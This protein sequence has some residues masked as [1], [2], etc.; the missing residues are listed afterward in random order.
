MKEIIKF[1]SITMKAIGRD[2]GMYSLNDLWRMLGSPK[3]Q[4]TRHWNFFC[5]TPQST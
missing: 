1:N 5:L 2:D 4:D 3:S